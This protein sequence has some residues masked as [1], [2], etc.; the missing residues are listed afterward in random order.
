MRK[1]EFSKK[2]KKNVFI[3]VTGIKLNAKV[4]TSSKSFDDRL[5]FK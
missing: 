5:K 4:K 2:K 1:R 3:Y